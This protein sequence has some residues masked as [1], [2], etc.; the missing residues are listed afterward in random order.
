MVVARLPPEPQVSR[1]PSLPF[2]TLV[3]PG[4]A[5]PSPSASSAQIVD[6]M[7][8]FSCMPMLSVAV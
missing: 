4:R 5:A 1:S 7:G 3:H 8:T 2:A 6:G